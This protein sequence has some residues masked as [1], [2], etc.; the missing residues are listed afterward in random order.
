MYPLLPQASFGQCSL[1][2]NDFVY[3]LKGGILDSRTNKVKVWKMNLYKP[4]LQW[5]EVASMEVDTIFFSAAVY[6]NGI[7]ISGGWSSN[8]V[9]K[10][11]EFYNSSL[12]RWSAL[13]SM[14]E[15]RYNH[16]L[17]TC[18]DCL[19]CLGGRNKKCLS[20]VEMLSDVN[21]TWQHIQPMQTPRSNFAAVNCMDAIYAI[22]GYNVQHDSIKS[23]EKYD[24]K[25]NKWIYVQHMNIERCGHSACAMWDKIFVVGGKNA[26]NDFVFEIECYDPLS[27][28]WSIVGNT[29]EK[30]ARHSVV[31]I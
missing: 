23:V 27:D 30:L 19:F 1:K 18:N 26:K 25:S 24:S 31:A 13:P 8:D 16:R 4:N 5:D 11:A 20:S 12:N 22:G 6:E 17:V 29:Q 21:K 28:N 10:S 7:A 15:G 14:K 2:V 3:I 9:V